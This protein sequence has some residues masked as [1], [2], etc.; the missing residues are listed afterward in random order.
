MKRSYKDRYSKLKVC[1]TFLLVVTHLFLL[2]DVHFHTGCAGDW[3]TWA[4][5]GCVLF[6]LALLECRLAQRALFSGELT[7]CQMRLL[8]RIVQ[9]VNS[10]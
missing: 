4:V 10:L 1:T 9:F 7:L 5:L 8:R 6:Q 3:A 2:T